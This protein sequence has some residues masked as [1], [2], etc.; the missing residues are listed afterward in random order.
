VADAVKW[1]GTIE[2]KLTSQQQQIAH[3]VLKEINE[4]LA[5]S[6]NVGSTTSTSTAPAARSRAGRASDPPRQPDRQRPV[7][8]ASMCSTSLG[9]ASTSAT[10]EPAARN[11]QAAARS[12]QHVIVVEHDEDA[13]RHDRPHRRSRA[14]GAGVHGGEIVAQGHA[15]AGLPRELDSLTGKYLTAARADRECRSKRRKGN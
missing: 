9:S 7:G 12:R 13:I 10:N 15:W 5:S 14:P 6:H 1:F 11:A 2:A 4:R 3:A 8:R